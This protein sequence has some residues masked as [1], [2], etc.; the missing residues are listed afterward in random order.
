MYIEIPNKFS[1]SKGNKVIWIWEKSLGYKQKRSAETNK[2]LLITSTE[3]ACKWDFFSI[4]IKK[5]RQEIILV[6][7]PK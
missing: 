5:K 7:P 1:S 6:D 4:N 2:L 3:R